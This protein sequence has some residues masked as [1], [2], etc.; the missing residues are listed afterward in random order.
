MLF[1][2]F[3]DSESILVKKRKYLQQ[4]QYYHDLK[5]WALGEKDLFLPSYFLTY[6]YERRT[7]KGKENYWKPHNTRILHRFIMR[8]VKPAQ[9]VNYYSVIN[10]YG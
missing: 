3:D 10:I 4:T 2:S 5:T 7:F 8:N 1:L 9:L 6:V